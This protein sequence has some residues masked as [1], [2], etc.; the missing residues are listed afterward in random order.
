MKKLSSS[1]LQ[2][3]SGGLSNK[4]LIATFVAYEILKN[5]TI[6]Y[7]LYSASAAGCTAFKQEWYSNKSNPSA[8]SWEN[9][10]TPAT[11]SIDSCLLK[12]CK[13]S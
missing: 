4:V 13:I 9:H 6:P 5:P 1:Q 7:N 8:N 11:P 10:K 12:D 3:V 2:T